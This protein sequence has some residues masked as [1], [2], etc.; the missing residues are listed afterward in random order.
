M[1][2]L[3]EQIKFKADNCSNSTKE[4]RARKGAYVDCIMMIKQALRQSDVSGQFYCWSEECETGRCENIC[5]AC[6][7]YKGNKQ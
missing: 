1:K 5:D 6:K 7:K 2:E 3:I 4:S